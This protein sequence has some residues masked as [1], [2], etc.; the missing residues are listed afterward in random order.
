MYYLSDMS[1]VVQTIVF[2]TSAVGW[3]CCLGVW[4]HEEEEHRR[5]WPFG[6]FIIFFSIFV[7]FFVIHL[8]GLG[9]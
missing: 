6:G 2:L 7:T 3:M 9:G 8:T 4:L 1:E 5:V